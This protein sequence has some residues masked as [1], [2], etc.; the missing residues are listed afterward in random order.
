MTRYDL[1][2]FL[3][4]ASVIVWLGAGTTLSLIV[5]YARRARDPVLLERLGAITGWL[6]PRVF[7]PA[8]LAA[9]GFGIAAARSGDW[10]DQ[11]WIRLGVAAFAVSFVLNVAVRLPLVRRTRNGSTDPIRAAR[12]LRSLAL[13]ELTMLY[14]TVGDMVAKPSGGD[15]GALATGGAILALAVFVALAAATRPVPARAAPG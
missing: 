2:V 1:W 13:V 10:P 12:A 8:S 7:A 4:V 9:L 15:T 11:L 14:L 5:L 6:G 3:H